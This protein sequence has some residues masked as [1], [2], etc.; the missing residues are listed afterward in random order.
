[1]NEL[2]NMSDDQIKSLKN[3]ISARKAQLKT[4]EGFDDAKRVMLGM[5][6]YLQA[7]GYKLP[8]TDYDQMAGIY[9]DQLRDYIA[10]F[11]Y[12]VIKRAV[13]QF[14]QEDDSK[15]HQ[16]PT[17]GQIIAV[18]KRVNG[19]PL[20]EIAKRQ[21]EAEIARMVDREHR[22]L[23]SKVTENELKELE[24]KYERNRKNKDL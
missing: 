20:S 14:V 2:A 21:L 11:G 1:M 13:R 23:M 8:D 6:D 19:N 12:D 7:S 15:Y 18:I 5:F 3:E 17:S 16:M 9:A 24:A 10:T 4:K 22:E